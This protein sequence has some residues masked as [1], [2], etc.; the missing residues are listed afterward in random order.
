L[1]VSRPHHLNLGRVFGH[2][3]DARKVLLGF[4][5]TLHD[6]QQTYSKDTIGILLIPVCKPKSHT[7]YLKKVKWV[8]N[9][10]H[11]QFKYAL[12]WNFQ[13]TG[14]KL[15]QL[16]VVF[17]SILD[18]HAELLVELFKSVLALVLNGNEL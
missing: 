15:N 12:L 7:K 13:V 5:Q 1:L 14:P 17:V 18:A 16:L 11:K 4:V 2:L 8:Q 3:L 9:L 6:T 10:L